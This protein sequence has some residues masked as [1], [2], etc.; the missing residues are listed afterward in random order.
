MKRRK[1]EAVSPVIGVI[2]MVAITVI[3][4]AVIGSF[5]FGMG[6]K[7]QSAPQ[8]QLMIEDN[9]NAVTTGKTD[10]LFDVLHYGGDDL[11]CADIKL[12]VV[13]STTTD[14][15]TWDGTNS[16]FNGSYLNT[17]AISDGVL[18]VGESFTV[19]ENNVSDFVGSSTTL[20]LRVIHIPTGNIIYE[21]NVRVA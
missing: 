14:T 17:T 18:S 12:Q 15:L 13:N 11:T 19:Q 1:D 8:V 20:T 9:T 16:I 4:A 2:L 5:V 7:V 3:L 6:S 21:A 10:A